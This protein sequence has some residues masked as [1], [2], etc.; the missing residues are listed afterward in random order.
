VKTEQARRRTFSPATTHKASR[1]TASLRLMAF[2]NNRVSITS[3]SVVLYCVIFPVVSPFVGADASASASYTGEVIV[4]VVVV[5]VVIVVVICERSAKVKR[6]WKK[7]RESNGLIVHL[8]QLFRFCT[9]TSE[10][11]ARE[12]TL[13]LTFLPHEKLPRP[14]A[15]SRW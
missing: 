7:K 13:G 6:R 8:S 15:R 5:V 10:G 3:S 2:S 1:S 14:K 9:V 12:L 11:S 4:V